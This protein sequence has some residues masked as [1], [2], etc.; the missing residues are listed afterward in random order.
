[1]FVLALPYLVLLV[2]LP[3]CWYAGGDSHDVCNGK[4][5]FPP[6]E[7]PFKLVTCGDKYINKVTVH[8]P[9]DKCMHHVIVILV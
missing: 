7:K 8:T 3:A 1:M 9:L 5:D 2:L 6:L 4:D